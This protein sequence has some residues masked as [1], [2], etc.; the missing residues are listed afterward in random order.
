LRTCE[1]LES[2]TREA[3]EVT[4]LQ[5]HGVTN[6]PWNR[7]S[8]KFGNLLKFEF[9]GCGAW[10]FLEQRDSRISRKPSQRHRLK[11]SGLVCELVAGL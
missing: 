9:R 8:M 2:W 3:P 11:S 4:N 10:W 5:R 6:L 7:E 1:A